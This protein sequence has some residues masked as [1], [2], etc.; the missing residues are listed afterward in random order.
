M[1]RMQVGQA[2]HT[3]HLAHEGYFLFHR[4][5][6][7][8]RPVRAGHR[9][10]HS[11]QAPARADVDN[12]SAFA[13]LQGLLQWRYDRQAVDHVLHQH[14][15]G[16]AYSRQVVCS[17]PALHL[18]QVLQQQGL[19]LRRQV[20]FKLLHRLGKLLFQVCLGH[21]AARRPCWYRFIWISNSEMAAGVT[22]EMRLAWPMVSGCAALSRCLT[23]M[24]RL[25]MAS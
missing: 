7:M 8:D 19:A 25:W 9:D 18:C 4:V 24:D 6:T 10:D 15:P 21:Y 23:S 16:V 17:V 22:P 1:N 11:G 3:R 14:L 12:G 13:A 20:D 2:Q 5:D